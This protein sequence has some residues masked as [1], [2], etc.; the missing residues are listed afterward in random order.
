MIGMRIGMVFPA[1]NLNPFTV[2]VLIMVLVCSLIPAIA[3]TAHAAQQ[4]DGE[5][6][7]APASFAYAV[8]FAA[9]AENT[10][11]TM[12]FDGKP[13]YQVFFMDRP[14][15]LI[16]ELVGADFRY[17]EPQQDALPGLL[18]ASRHGRINNNRSRMVLSLTSPA[19]VLDKALVKSD[20]SDRHT[21]QLILTEI[22]RGQF[23]EK[24]AKQTALLGTSGETVVKG[25]RVR[26]PTA[27]PG[28][29][30]VVIDPGHGG[31]DGGATGFR[32]KVLEKDIVL[33]MGLLLGELIERSGPFHVLY[34]RT[35]DVFVSLRERQRFARRSNADLMISLHADSLR[36]RFVRGLTVYTLSENASDS[37]SRELAESENLSD[38]VAGLAAPDARDEVTDILAD[39]TMRETTRFSRSFANR[40]VADL[41]NRVKL[42]NNPHRSASF[43]V[44]K[45]AE[46]PA[47]LVEMGYLSNAEDEDLLTD[48]D[49]QEDLVAILAEAVK[50]YFA[51]RQPSA[52]AN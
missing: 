26:P 6:E 36:Q 11:V 1:R 34:T 3:V 14:D 15:R 28:Q 16:V 13:D 21:L 52:S 43:M 33:K 47:V 22:E 45:N 31:I 27:K 39:L 29:F 25:D 7:I 49:W 37:L 24:I 51:G 42:I 9:D 50:G 17:E 4:D 48:P 44:L 41:R 35:E 5:Q 2:L 46:V 20:D 40:L 10:I 38:V 30:T 8:E 19:T 23:T 32:S 12:K 18:T